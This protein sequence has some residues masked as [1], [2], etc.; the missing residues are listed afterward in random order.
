MNLTDIKKMD[1]QLLQSDLL[2]N[3]H[4]ELAHKCIRFMKTILNDAIDNDFLYKNPC[5][6]IKE[7]KIVREEKVILTPEQDIALLNSK[8]KYAPYF[9]IIRYTGMRKEEI[10]ALTKNDIDFDNMTISINKAFSYVTNKPKLK[11]TKNKKKRTVPILKIIYKDIKL[12]YNNSSFYLFEKEDGNVL[13][14]EAIR[15]MTK[16]I[17][18]DLGFKIAPHQL[19]HCYCTMLY[20]SGITIKQTQNL[21]GH[22]SAK[23]VYDLYAHLNEQQEQVADTVNMYIDKLSKGC[24]MK[25]KTKQTY[26]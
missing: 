10:S 8:N 11:E 25:N 15:Y 13:T 23:M 19:R 18:K 16:S 21:M 7:P 3:N 24:Q 2:Q 12:V 14:A 26:I 20:Y 5:N 9:R 4:Y 17:C 1:I 6:S 22:S